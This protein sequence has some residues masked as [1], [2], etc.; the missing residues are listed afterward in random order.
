VTHI[1]KLQ[2]QKHEHNKNEQ[3]QRMA[4]KITI[5]ISQ[6]KCSHYNCSKKTLSTFRVITEGCTVHTETTNTSKTFT[7]LIWKLHCHFQSLCVWTTE[8]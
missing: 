7:N 3:K 4:Y 5:N 6:E 2:T 1:T 8:C